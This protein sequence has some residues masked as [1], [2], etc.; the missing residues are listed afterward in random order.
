MVLKS[1]DITSIP[2]GLTS[3]ME[4]P[5]G[6]RQSILNLPKSRCIK[7]SR[8]WDLHSGITSHSRMHPRI[9]RRSKSS[10]CLLSTMMDADGHLTREPV[11]PV[12][13]GDVLLRSLRIVVLLTELNQL[14]LWGTDIGNTYLETHTKEKLFI[15]A[16]PELDDLEGHILVMDKALYGT[17]TAGASWH[18]CLFDVLKKIGFN[19]SKALP[20]VLM[21]PAEDNSC[22]EYIAVYV[23]DLAIS[24]K[25]SKKITDDLQSNHDRIW[26]FTSNSSSPGFSIGKFDGCLLVSL[27]NVTLKTKTD[28]DASAQ[29]PECSC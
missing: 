22:Y 21:R 27:I 16:G 3:K 6:K 17:R 2:S 26:C 15:V 7:L 20:D 12:H 23:D 24:A 8:I 9:T 18:D 19:P 28:Q 5:S 11:E 25:D 29:E 1:P 13:S 14:E 4:T 10:L